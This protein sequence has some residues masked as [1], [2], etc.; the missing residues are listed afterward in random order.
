MSTKYNPRIVSDGLVIYFDPANQR[1]YPNSGTLV[2]SLAGS[3]TGTMTNGVGFS[4]F[5]TGY[6]SFDGTNDYISFSN[7][8]TLTNQ[9]TISVW[10]KPSDNSGISWVTGREGS[11]RI[12]YTSS[13][14]VWDCATTNNGW[15]TNGTD[16]VSNNLSVMNNW[17]NVVG[18]YDGSNIRLYI[19]G[20]LHSTGANISG[21]ILT[22]G[23][24]LNL[25]QADNIQLVVYG[26]GNIGQYILYNRA[27]S[28]QEILQNYNATKMRYL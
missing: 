16:V 28:S 14:F 6:F 7:N 8:P 13:V 17:W 10:I 18:T 11:Y 26:K 23:Y 19:N 24:T 1:S 15:Y 4:T 20:S 21:N 5:N 3:I 27:L 25:M 12:L 2:R 9:I 22:T